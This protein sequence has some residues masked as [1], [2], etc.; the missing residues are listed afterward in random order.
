MAAQHVLYV[1]IIEGL[2]REKNYLTQRNVH[3]SFQMLWWRLN[4]S[5]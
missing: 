5:P 1:V 3:Y 4:L 2:H